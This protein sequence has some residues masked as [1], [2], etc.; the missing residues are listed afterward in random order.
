M[1]WIWAGC[2]ICSPLVSGAIEPCTATLSVNA[3]AAM[4]IDES[5]FNLK[6]LLFPAIAYNSLG[7]LHSQ[8]EIPF[9]RP[10]NLAPGEF[11]TAPSFPSSPTSEQLCP[12]VTGTSP[13][14]TLLPPPAVSATGSK[15]NG[16]HPSAPQPP[17]AGSFL[18]LPAPRRHPGE[19]WHPHSCGPRSQQVQT[20]H[21][22]TAHSQPW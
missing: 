13:L 10:P 3:S 1:A 14:F 22:P 15:V 12:E 16:P 20:L 5:Y 9:S 19:I 17:D 2:V 18:S 21:S 4:F 8:V 6:L 11:I 7:F